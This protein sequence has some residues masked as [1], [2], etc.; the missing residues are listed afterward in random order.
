MILI[1]ISTALFLYLFFTTMAVLFL[2]T[3]AGYRTRERTFKKDVEVMRRCSIC[4][5]AYIDSKD[6]A[7]S[8]CPQCGSLN[9]K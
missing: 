2:W 4:A 7:L 3:Y 1:D 8:R 5:N 9:E 6:S